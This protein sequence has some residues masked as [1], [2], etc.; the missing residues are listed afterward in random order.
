MIKKL[1]LGIP[2]RILLV[3]ILF[4]II[5]GLMNAYL[6]TALAQITAVNIDEAKYLQAAF[7]FV[8][9]IVLWEA[10]EF[11]CDACAGIQ[12]AHV[13]N[14][15]FRTYYK[16]IY[17]TKPE[18]LQHENT[19]YVAGILTQLIQQKET[20]L[21]D[22]LVAGI[23]IVY[24]IYL[25]IYISMYSIW[26][27][28]LILVLTAI[29]LL[30]RLVCSKK[31][32]SPF[33]EM[34]SVRGE[35]SRIF[36]DGINNIQTVQK[37]RALDFILKKNEALGRN[38]LRKTRK[39]IIG[40]EIGFTLYK[41][42]NYMLCPIGMFLALA[43]YRQNP[44]FP[45][46]QFL[47][48]LT[49]VT[50]QL[51]HNIRSIAAFIKDYGTFVTTQK[52]MDKL[53]ADSSAKYTQTSIGSDFSEIALK[54]VAYRY[55]FE[56]NTATIRI[57]DFR[58]SKGDFICITG[59]SGQ[60]KTTLLK[61]LSGMLETTGNL[62]VDGKETDQ[63]IDAVYIAQ[64]TEMLDMTLK[65][66]LSLGSEHISDNEMKKMLYEVGLGEW[67]ENQKEG[68]NTLLGERGVF[69]STGQRQRLNLIRGLLIDKEIYF[70]DEPTSNVDEKT[71]EKMIELIQEKLKGKTVIIVTHKEK[72]SE[73]CNERYLFENNCLR[74]L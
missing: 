5:W 21:F 66:N 34:T 56:Q 60:G 4:T 42:I 7:F 65:E 26:F 71:E 51:V 64:D 36:M 47:S 67:F 49:I 46:V 10:V 13:R 17:L 39:F 9:Y 3:N 74:K 44:E 22:W 20:V 16:K 6:T 72:I 19:G 8:I 15:S 30:I 24:V 23:S 14:E 37:L 52:E 45:V 55:Q 12:N 53:V 50:V 43:V 61:L 69:V 32:E 35:Q 63:N 70:L 27:T 33:R 38:N 48:Y 62:F 59:E 54:E 57:D 18:T 11:V 29:G 31:I 41:G 40:N 1:F 25:A 2:K 68:L 73:I 58:I 28:V